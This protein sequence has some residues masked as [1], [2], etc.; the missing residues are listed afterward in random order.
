VVRMCR[1]LVC[2]FSF[3]FLMGGFSFAADEKGGDMQITEKIIKLPAPRLKSN[4]SLEE[5][6]YKRRSKRRFTQQGLTLEQV[7][8]ILWSAQG[9]TNK[10]GFRTVPSAGALYPLEIYAMKKDG[11]FHY[12]QEDH[13]IKLLS[14]K[15]LRSRL[16]DAAWGQSF[17]EEAPLDIIICAVYSRVTSKY[18]QRGTRYTDIEVGHAGQNIQLQAVALGLDS[19]VVGAFGLKEV[20]GL[21]NLP[22]DEEPLYIIPIGYTK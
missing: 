19:C 18:G 8:Q 9:I 22:K 3:G 12:I 10:A 14:N 17:I 21:M 2:V 15:D 11:F 7:S 20:A 16:S 1:F 5:T 13:K 4:I 6:I